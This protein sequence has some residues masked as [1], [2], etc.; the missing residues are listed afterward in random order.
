MLAR[1]NFML[2]LGLL[3]LIAFYFAGTYLVI[4]PLASMAPGWTNPATGIILL[5]ACALTVQFLSMIMTN[6]RGIALYENGER[7][8]AL[9]LASQAVIVLGHIVLLYAAVGLLRGERSIGELQLLVVAA[10]YLTGAAI[11]VYEWRQR[12]SK[13]S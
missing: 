5:A 11:A 1:M 2:G 10:L 3:S 7:P 13:R 4:R 9:A 8:G 12:K 6:L